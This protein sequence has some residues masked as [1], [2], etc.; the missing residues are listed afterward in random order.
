MLVV[1]PLPSPIPPLS[2]F[3]P[4]AQAHPVDAPLSSLSSFHPR[5]VNHSTPMLFPLAW[6][7]QPLRHLGRGGRPIWVTCEGPMVLGTSH[8]P[9]PSQASVSRILIPQLLPPWPRGHLCP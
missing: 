6:L 5:G 9:L 2:S 7:P 3:E 1:F 8:L 4:P